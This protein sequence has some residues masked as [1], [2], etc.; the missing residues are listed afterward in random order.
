MKSEQLQYLEKQI[1]DRDAVLKLKNNKDF[2][3]IFNDYYFK[4]YCLNLTKMSTL[5]SNANLQDL[6]LRKAQACIYTEQFLEQII[7]LGNTAEKNLEEVKDLQ[8]DNE[9]L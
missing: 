3:R 8:E 2:K 6:T 7:A 4:E 9:E 5:G 1:Q